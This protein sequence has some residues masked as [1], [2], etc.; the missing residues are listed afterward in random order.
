MQ[1][2]LSV[3]QLKTYESVKK[4]T[5][6]IKQILLDNT[7]KTIEKYN[8]GLKSI[9]I[10]ELDNFEKE[11]YQNSN[12]ISV[13]TSLGAIQSDMESNLKLLY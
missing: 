11:F 8:K 6:N 5:H 9:S 4:A 2:Q 12:Q 10:E 3:L 1:V 7:L 13:D